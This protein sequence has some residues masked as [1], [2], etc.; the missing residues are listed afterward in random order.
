MHYLGTLPSNSL[1]AFAVALMATA[2]ASPTA[3]AQTAIE[4]V[5][6][7]ARKREEN[8]QSVPLSISVITE[9]E[10]LRAN[11]VSLDDIAEMTPGFSFNDVN[12]AYQNPAI[13]GL[14]QTD[15][16]SLEGNVGIFIDGVYLDNR[17]GLEFGMIELERV[18]VVKGPQSAL[19]GRNTFAGAINYVTKAPSL[20]K[21]EG[22]V[23]AT[24]GNYKRWSARAS[25][26]VPIAD[27]LAVRA[28]AGASEFGG[29]ITNIRNGEKLGGYRDRD[30]FGGQVLFQ[31]SDEFS[32]K[33]FAA[34]NKRD[35]EQPAFRVIP[36]A[37]N[38]CGPVFNVAPLGQ[39]VIPVNALF[40]GNAP[41]TR[42]VT[43]DP[44]GEGTTGRVDL[45]Y[46]TLAYDFG[47]V[48]VTGQVSHTLSK[49]STF[50]DQAG[51]PTAFQRR[52]TGN[53]SLQ[54]FT[55]A[56]S[57]TGNGKSYELRLES[58]ADQRVRWLIGGSAFNT[59]GGTILASTATPVGG[60]SPLSPISRVVRTLRS[61]EKAAFASAEADVT[62]DFKISAEM[63]YTD[64][65]QDFSGFTA[66]LFL[67]IPP[68]SVPANSQELNTWT[69]RFT[70]DY[71]VTPE[72]MLYASAARGW[73]AGGFN[74]AN[75]PFRT[76]QPETNW[77]YE[78]GFKSTLFDGRAL[79]NAAVYYIDWKSL[80]IPAPIDV[81]GSTAIVN[82]GGATSTGIEI[83]TS[84]AV[85]DEF[86]IRA[87]IA[88]LDPKFKRGVTDGSL[89]TICGRRPDSGIIS[90]P[91][92]IDVG[93]NRIPK[94]SSVQGSFSGTYTVADAFGDFD[95]YLRADFSHQ[96]AKYVN[97][98]NFSNA[99]DI[100]LVNLRLGITD[101][102]LEVAVWMDN[103]L[104]ANWIRSLQSVL[105]P[106]INTPCLTR[107]QNCSTQLLRVYAGDRRTIGVTAT[108]R[109]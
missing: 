16:L 19:Y 92:S 18:E 7:T 56:A 6:V 10:L 52:L 86:L 14:A 106:G 65:H 50:I 70:A 72:V 36:T 62:D 103:A 87:G 91:C 8:L 24:G 9:S 88:V 17:S 54:F 43:L 46:G 48:K 27:T 25:V 95:A 39:P 84:V 99:R 30:S 75:A 78:A 29:T 71:Q 101:D 23:E 63:R 64:V 98:L 41:I 100:N 74:T 69:P 77:S 32:L 61:V 79:F 97:S 42:D 55:N 93:G 22:V 53:F 81:I 66:L 89:F 104:N 12:G 73:K 20:E 31:P 51:D 68:I 90:P 57:D 85:T 37:A 3:Y 83:D 80:Q 76:Y 5:V 94:V 59:K 34:R 102:N 47:A 13:R 60:T 67:P 96:G 2:L 1:K 44:R 109:F 33:V 82:L 108:R 49:F 35:D 21:F 40:C 26:N 58:S 11:A 4:E 45:I 38:N 105:D 107:G 15:Q 28:F